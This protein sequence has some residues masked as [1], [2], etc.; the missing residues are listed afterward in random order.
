M[1]ELLTCRVTPTYGPTKRS[2]TISRTSTAPLA[3][4]TSAV[5]RPDGSGRVSIP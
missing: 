1:T 5:A 3:Q 2:A 4:K